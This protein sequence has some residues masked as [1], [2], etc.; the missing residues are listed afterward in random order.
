MQYNALMQALQAIYN[1]VFCYG[2]L[3]YGRILVMAAW[4]QA[5]ALG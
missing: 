5:A 1:A 3:S 2:P 4:V